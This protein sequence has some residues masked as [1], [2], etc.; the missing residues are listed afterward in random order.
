MHLRFELRRNL[1]VNNIQWVIYYTIK[2]YIDIRLRG[3]LA[4]IIG[5]N[6]HAI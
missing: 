5:V 4:Y 6:M 2:W 3:K 1:E